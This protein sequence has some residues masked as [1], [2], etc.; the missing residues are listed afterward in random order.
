L[1]ADSGVDPDCAFVGDEMSEKI[2]VPSGMLDAACRQTW[3]NHAR[4]QVEEIVRGALGWLSENPIVPTHTQIDAMQISCDLPVFAHHGFERICEEWQRHMFD[5]QEPEPPE[6]LKKLMG[7]MDAYVDHAPDSPS[8]PRDLITEAY[9][10]GQQS[11]DR[12]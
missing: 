4:S 11:K 10:L 8:F 1:G 12:P 5:A 9:R 6:E 7:M 2:Q 3:A